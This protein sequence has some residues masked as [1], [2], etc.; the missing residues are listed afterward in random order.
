MR[1]LHRSADTGRCNHV[2]R[3]RL[4]VL[5]ISFYEVF[6]TPATTSCLT[7]CTVVVVRRES[8]IPE[9]YVGDRLTHLKDHSGSLALMLDKSGLRQIDHDPGDNDD[10][11]GDIDDGCITYKEVQ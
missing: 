4:A 8:E 11:D 6:P 1:L 5:Y 7:E 2:W 10:T 9:I 3:S